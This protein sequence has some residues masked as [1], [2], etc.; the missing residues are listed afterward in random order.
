MMPLLRTVALAAVAL[1][2][3][4]TAACSTPTPSAVEGTPPAFEATS[5]PP[6]APAS[7]YDTLKTAT[8]F[9]DAHIGYSGSLSPNAAAFR[10]ILASPDPKTTMRALYTEGTVVGKLYAV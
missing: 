1:S 2:G 3:L 9:E 10:A 4:A 5:P 8:V 7:A 6:Q